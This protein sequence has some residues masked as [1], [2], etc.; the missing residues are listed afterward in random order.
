MSRKFFFR[1]LVGSRRGTSGDPSVAQWSSWVTTGN[2]RW[3]GDQRRLR[4]MRVMLTIRGLAIENRGTTRRS[5][6]ER[7]NI[8]RKYTKLRELNR[9]GIEVW[10]ARE[11]SSFPKLKELLQ[12]E[13]GAIG[14]K[15]HGQTTGDHNE[16][17]IWSAER[18]KRRTGCDCFGFWRRVSSDRGRSCWSCEQ[19]GRTGRKNSHEALIQSQYLQTH[20]P[21]GC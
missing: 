16:L 5:N 18:L 13:V 11:R 21:V 8:W 19:N 6:W 7:E 15:R 9:Q 4:G 3:R 1:R 14:T 2:W 12:N 10:T 20:N 17:L